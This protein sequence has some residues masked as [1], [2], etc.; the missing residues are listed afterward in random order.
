MAVALSASLFYLT[1]ARHLW[2]NK[3]ITAT[4]PRLYLHRIGH[5]KLRFTIIPW[6][7]SP[8]HLS[9]PSLRRRWTTTREASICSSHP[10]QAWDCLEHSTSRYSPTRA[11]ATSYAPSMR[12]SLRMSTPTWSSPPLPTN[13]Y[14]HPTRLPLALCFPMT[15]RHSCHY[16]SAHDYAVAR[17]VSAL[18]CELLVAA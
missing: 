12:D 5:F 7:L 10:S 18:N 8:P 1:T 15:P 2:L 9:R 17:V 14:A 4:Q 6:L 11:Y 16:E 13:F 3:H